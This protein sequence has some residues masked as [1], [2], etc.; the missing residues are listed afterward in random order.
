MDALVMLS[1][2]ED[3]L[4]SP[5]Q[6]GNM[7]LKLDVPHL[8]GPA[9]G[10]A[11]VTENVWSFG[12]VAYATVRVTAALVVCYYSYHIPLTSPLI[13]T[14]ICWY[15]VCNGLLQT[16]SSRPLQSYRSKASALCG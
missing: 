16:V 5:S 12:V 2:G 1:W 11:P 14:C 3:F 10:Y 15:C 13:A 6:R 4:I 9:L 8:R 7:R